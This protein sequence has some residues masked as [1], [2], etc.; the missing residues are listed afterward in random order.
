MKYLDR[1]RE[2]FHT[3]FECLNP[4]LSTLRVLGFTQQCVSHENIE[5]SPLRSLSLDGD[6]PKENTP[7]SA[8]SPKKN[9][10]PEPAYLHVLSLPK[11]YPEMRQQPI[12]EIRQAQQDIG[13]PATNTKAGKPSESH[14]ELISCAIMESSEQRLIL[15]DIYQYIYDNYPYFQTA[16][17][18]WRNTVRYNLSTNEC[19]IKKGRAPSGRFYWAI[20]PACVEDFDKREFNRRLARQRV[21]YATRGGTSIQQ[22]G[23]QD[24]MKNPLDGLLPPAVSSEILNQANINYQSLYHATSAG[25][26]LNDVMLPSPVPCRTNIMAPYSTTDNYAYTAPQMTQSPCMTP[27]QVPVSSQTHHT[28][29]PRMCYQQQM[30]H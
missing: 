26:S 20:H 16:P 14:V 12:E 5:D 10:L 15:A 24:L 9:T 23:L 13:K 29:D 17:R 27:Q 22:V 28:A 21:Q 11:S 25:I 30:Y 7:Y 6:S 4:T 1:L 3:S 18:G 2:S 19:F 8:S